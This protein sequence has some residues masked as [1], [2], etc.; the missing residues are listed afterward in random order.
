MKTVTKINETRAKEA[1]ALLNEAWAYYTPD[2][3]PRS[4]LD[5]DQPALFQYHNAA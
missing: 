3:M 1:L 2:A 5:S 4:Q